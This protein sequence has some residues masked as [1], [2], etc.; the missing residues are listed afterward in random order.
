ME[1]LTTIIEAFFQNM[2][3]VYVL[4][5]LLL[6][7]VYL[8]TNR[9]YVNMLHQKVYLCAQHYVQNETSSVSCKKNGGIDC[10]KF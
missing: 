4:C 10:Y 6:I 7:K 5:T 2:Y 8:N 3:N 1:L 9:M